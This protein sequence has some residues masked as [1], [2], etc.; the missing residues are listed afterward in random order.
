MSHDDSALTA[1]AVDDSEEV[2]SKKERAAVAEMVVKYLTPYYSNNR[3]S[4]KV[5]LFYCP[6][7]S[8]I[9]KDESMELIP[10]VFLHLVMY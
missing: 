3:F 7:V 8:L 9:L 5:L 6:T 4:S 10:I 1:S 2:R